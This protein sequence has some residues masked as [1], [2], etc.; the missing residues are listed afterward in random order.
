MELICLGDSLTYGYGIR[1]AL[2]WSSLVGE[3]LDIPVVNC[4]VN[5]DTTGGMLARLQ[6]D[7][8]DRLSPTE[9]QRRNLVLVMG[10]TNDILF[11]GSDQ[12]ARAN[13]GAL[14]H[15]LAGAGVEVA[16][17]IPPPVIPDRVKGPWTRAVDVRAAQGV[18]EEYCTWLRRFCDAFSFPMVDFRQDFVG[19]GGPISELFLDGI[20]PTEEGHRRMA[21]R[22]VAL[23]GDRRVL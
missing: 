15:Q 6:S 11:S 14:A 21:E 3:Q 10:G 13:L 12:S 16:I 7:V 4:G 1:R 17:G 23:L 19:S 20:H 5:G 22:C 9:R 8:L 18:L 2:R